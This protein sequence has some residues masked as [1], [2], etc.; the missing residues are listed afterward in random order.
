ML[1]VQFRYLNRCHAENE[2]WFKLL[3]RIIVFKWDLT[4]EFTLAQS[5]FKTASRHVRGQSVRHVSFLDEHEADRDTFS[6]QDPIVDHLI[7]LL[8]SL[9]KSG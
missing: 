6:L 1:E 9:P 7:A 8:L 2:R 5:L 3:D 4:K